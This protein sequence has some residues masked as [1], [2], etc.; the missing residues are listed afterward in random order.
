MAEF[1]I[2][3]L[4]PGNLEPKHCMEPLAVSAVLTT[5]SSCVS[6]NQL[7]ADHGH[8]P[9]MKKVF[10]VYLCFLQKH[11]SETALKNVFTALRSL[12]YKVR[13]VIREGHNWLSP[14]VLFPPGP[15]GNIKL[16]EVYLLS[17]VPSSSPQRSMK[18]EPTCVRLCATRFWSAATP[19]W[20]PSGPRP[21]SCSTSSCATT[22]TTQGRSPSSGHTCKCV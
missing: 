6:K 17:P 16:P 15:E 2:I 8:N 19:N 12:I 22:S 11:Q 5:L 10:D 7:L 9:L 3:S 13:C 14:V 21:P 4:V 1:Y 18:G 20:A